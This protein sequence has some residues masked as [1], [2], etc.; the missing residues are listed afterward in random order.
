MGACVGMRG[1][2]V[3][4]IVREL[5][6]ERIDIIN[7]TDELSLLVRR[8][9]APAEVKRVIPVG[10]HK[11]VVVI[12]EEDLAQ[13]IGR[14]GQNI[15]LASKML[16]KEIDVFGDEE[17]AAMT[18]E[19]RNAALSEAV[20]APEKTPDF[21]E[22]PVVKK[23]APAGYSMES[24]DEDETYDEAFD[25]MREEARGERFI[26]TTM[27][28]ARFWEILLPVPLNRWPN[29]KRFKKAIDEAHE[30]KESS[31]TGNL[32]F[33]EVQ[34]PASSTVHETDSAG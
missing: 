32:I 31:S 13:A 16:D 30:N 8:V 10:E 14:E 26:K 34:I 11:I 1:N 2:R 24:D 29:P 3:Q 5:S 17:F 33:Q 6:N 20:A 23:A 27:R 12:R 4:A 22:G 21:P 19:Q 18:D 15:R 7:W 25:K 28:T 9:F